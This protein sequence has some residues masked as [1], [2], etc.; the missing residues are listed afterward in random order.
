M[1]DSPPVLAWAGTDNSDIP[2]LAL[3][4]DDVIKQVCQKRFSNSPPTV[5]GMET[6]RLGDWVVK[7]KSGYY[8][9]IES[10]VFKERFEVK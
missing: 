8:Q 10:D 2:I 4:K 1:Q 7:Y 3:K 6:L 9:T 5:V